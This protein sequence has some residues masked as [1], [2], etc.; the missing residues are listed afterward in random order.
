MRL[1]ENDHVIKT[2]APDRSEPAFDVR[3]LLRTRRSGNDFGDAS[4]QCA[5]HAIVISFDV[6]SDRAGAT[7]EV[8]GD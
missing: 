2:P 4:R 1:I 3:I 7:S 8:L 6:A 5:P